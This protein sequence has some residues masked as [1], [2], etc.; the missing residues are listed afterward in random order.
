MWGVVCCLSVVTGAVNHP[1]PAQLGLQSQQGH[2]VT[3]AEGTGS[4]DAA[5]R[6]GFHVRDECGF[7]RAFIDFITRLGLLCSEVW[8][9]HL[10][11]VLQLLQVF[12]DLMFS[13]SFAS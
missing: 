4:W 13:G 11:S 12:T 9:R 5:Q 2:R 6:D 10:T 8:A 3:A 1:F 7:V